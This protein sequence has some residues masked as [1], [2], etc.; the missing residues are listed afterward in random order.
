VFCFDNNIKQHSFG[1]NIEKDEISMVDRTPRVLVIVLCVA[2]LIFLIGP[3]FKYPAENW[4]AILQTFVEIIAIVMGGLWTYLTFIKDRLDYPYSK[5]EHKIHYWH[6]DERRIY[7]S[8]IVL[9]VN[10]G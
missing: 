9:F 8:V 3:A 2:I 4:A 5:Q 6:I 1:I 10:S 7:L